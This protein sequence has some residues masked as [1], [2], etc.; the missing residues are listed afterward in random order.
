LWQRFE[1]LGVKR[2]TLL[3]IYE[4]NRGRVRRA[5]I[6]IADAAASH[7]VATLVRSIDEVEESY[8]ASADAVIA[9]CWTPGN[10]P[11]GDAP[12]RRMAAWIEGLP[13]LNGKPAG[14]FCTYRFFPHTFADT[15]ARTA[16]TEHELASR[17][18]LKGARVIA[19]KAFHFDSIEKDAAE[20]VALVLE[21][22]E[23][24]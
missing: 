6:A 7:G 21:Q 1:G 24:V 4:G 19:T 2:M 23:R 10:V 20:L 14:V 18:E 16:E 12:T 5:A 11:F 17:L 13:N 15:A 22:T 8:L 3:V 9:G